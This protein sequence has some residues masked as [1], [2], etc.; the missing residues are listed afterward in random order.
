MDSFTIELGSNASSQVFPNNALSSFTIFLLE[1]V[2]LGGQW[3]VAISEI[4]YPSM[5]QNVTEGKF[6]FFNEKLSKTTKAYY[7]EPGLYSS[8]TDIVDA[9]NT[10]IQ[11][12][13]NHKESCIT[14]TVSG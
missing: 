4:S 9:M 13:N 1:Q 8:M 5:Y 12:K 14:I 3:D 10:I 7:L 11:E 6:M 2:N